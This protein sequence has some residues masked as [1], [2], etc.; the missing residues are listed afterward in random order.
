LS[1]SHKL[2]LPLIQIIET[3]LERES[4]LFHPQ[5]HWT[6]EKCSD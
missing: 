1:R 4:N 3:K 5:D 2:E 6:T